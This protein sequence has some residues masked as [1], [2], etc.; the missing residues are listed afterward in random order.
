[1]TL[2][3]SVLAFILL[4]TLLI[5]IHE[6]GHFT[7]AKLFKV[8]VEE[9][10]FGLPPKAVTL[11]THGMT[12]FTLNWIPFGGFVRLKG[13]NSI[14]TEQRYEKGSFAS[15]SAFARILILCG[16]VAMNFLL[17]FALL[18]F[19]FSV[20]K[21]VPHHYVTQQQLEQ[22]QVL[23][24]LTFEDGT[25]VQDVLKES[26]AEKA[27]IT[28]GSAIVAVDGTAI[29]SPDD[30]VRLQKDKL[31]VTYTV[32][33]GSKKL[34]RDVTIVLTDGKAGVAL[35]SK[36]ISANRRSVLRAIQLS[37]TEAIFMT[38][39]T[40]QGIIHLFKSLIVD[41]RVPDGIT[42]IV[43]IA[44]L[45]YVSVQ[46][47]LGTYLQLVALLSLSLA[48]L[49]ILPLPALDGGRLLF[50]LI[51]LVI[52]RPLNQQFELM[53]NAIGFFVLIA[54]IVIITLN[55]VIHLF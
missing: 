42:G 34:R 43:G 14:E 11:F 4:L 41:H 33:E 37:G 55:D 40:V 32:E 3:L 19:G 23:G 21:W 49:N 17:A 53:V 51:E 25:F 48:I 29:A 12:K 30:L 16:G 2:F 52:R 5:I 36:R 13:E 44:V 1:M 8:D 39:Q 24:E 15:A 31:S 54:L 46:D 7:L 28:K 22:A 20:G 9:F 27:G 38:E 35:T 47:G 10:G 18:V 50:V 26:S 45:T 6:L